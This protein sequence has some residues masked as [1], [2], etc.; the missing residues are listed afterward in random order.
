MQRSSSPEVE[1]DSV[2]GGDDAG[3]KLDS[4]R[5][6]PHDWWA[7]TLLA[8]AEGDAPQ[9]LDRLRL[10]LGHARSG[11]YWIGVPEPEHLPHAT[12]IALGCGDIDAAGALA[13]VA[14]RLARRNPAVAVINGVAAHA[15]AL[16]SP[17]PDG[18]RYAVR[19]L[20]DGRRP[21]A[22]A[23][24]QEDLGALYATRDAS[25]Q[26]IGLIEVAHQTYQRCGAA[27]DAARTRRRLRRLGVIKR[28]PAPARPSH[29]WEASPPPSC[30][31]AGWS[32][33][34]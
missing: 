26:A 34:V 29:G 18:F 27:R 19:L 15:A 14:A 30:R 2:L 16:V 11:W 28:Q 4:E 31:S 7:A 9:A 23:S 3:S 10:L 32:P 17:D 8:D 33:R 24:A 13:D 25:A 12:R 21:L 22:T 1:D 6:T 20:A 5:A